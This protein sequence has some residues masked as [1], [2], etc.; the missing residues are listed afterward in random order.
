MEDLPQIDS[1]ILFYFIATGWGVL[2]Q[3]N[4]CIFKTVCQ[5]FVGFTS[6]LK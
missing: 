1:K 4:F 3:S 5:V 6:N 2:T